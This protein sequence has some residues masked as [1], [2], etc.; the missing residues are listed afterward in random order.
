MTPSA[1]PPSGPCGHDHDFEE[2]LVQSM[3]EFADG[4]ASPTLDAGRI[5]R[6]ARRRR[7][8]MTG[9]SVAAVLA[10]VVGG[11]ALSTIAGSPSSKPAPAAATTRGPST[12]AAP[13]PSAARRTV[14]V[15]DVVG[16]SQAEATAV[17]ATARLRVG[18]VATQA[19]GAQPAG[20][21]IA[22]IPAPNNQVPSG[23][24]VELWIST[25]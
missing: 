5:G 10:V 23:S 4:T 20:R 6:R 7:F 19:D 11:T 2:R 15:P 13:R 21:V 8:A 9:A 18:T 22:T 3:N 25:R 14:Q 1:P 12:V 17:L 24:P 16:L